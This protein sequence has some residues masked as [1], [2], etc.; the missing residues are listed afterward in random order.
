M[1]I[2]VRR[3]AQTTRN[4]IFWSHVEV[5]HARVCAF[6]Q[7]LDL[8]KLRTVS[9]LLTVSSP[10]PL[11]DSDIIKLLLLVCMSR[12]TLGNKWASRSCYSISMKVT[13]PCLRCVLI[14]YWCVL[15]E[16][17]SVTGIKVFPGGTSEQFQSRETSCQWNATQIQSPLL[18][19]EP[20]RMKAVFLAHLYFHA[21]NGV[22]LKEIDSPAFDRSCVSDW[23]SSEDSRSQCNSALAS[24]W[25]FPSCPKPHIPLDIFIPTA[26]AHVDVSRLAGNCHWNLPEPL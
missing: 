8:R 5:K 16:L 4:L 17:Q 14:S 15:H 18:S 21:I 6:G 3:Q 11:H 10:I 19:L 20:I 12:T 2:W 26:P 24:F 25:K 1:G 13:T 7:E 22:I 9:P 23:K